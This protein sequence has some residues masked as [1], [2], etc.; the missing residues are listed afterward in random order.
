MAARGSRVLTGKQVIIEAA[1]TKAGIVGFGMLIMLVVVVA[2]V[3]IYAPFDVVSAWNSR[4]PWLDNPKVAAPEWMDWFTSRD[5]ARSLIVQ[6][7]DFTKSAGTN[8]EGTFK[9]IT[10]RRTFEWNSDEFP[11]E[12]VVR[13]FAQWIDGTPPPRV[14]AIWLRPDGESLELFNLFP[15]RRVPDINVIS[16]SQDAAV[17]ETVRSW[18]LGLGAEDQ[19]FIQPGSVIFARADGEHANNM[20]NTTSAAVLRGRYTLQLEAFAFDADDDVDS[21]FLAHGN[22]FGLVGTDQNRRDLF[23]GLLWGAPVALAFGTVAALLT[24]FSQVL[25]GALGAFYGGRWDEFIQRAADFFLILPVLPILILIGAFYTPSIWIILG[26]VVIF[27]LVGGTTKVIRSIVLQVKEDQ[28]IESARSYGASRWRILVRYILPRTLPYTF[29]LIALSVPAFIFLEAALSF[30]GLGDPL[31]PTW[32]KI[33]GDAQRSGA[34]FSGAWWWITFPALG[35]LFVTV[36]FA[37]LGYAFDKI[38]NP[39]L[40]EE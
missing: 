13:L 37:F 24:V 15:D 12:V 38:L 5:M 8:P 35:I 6:Q 10:L 11:S 23:I 29:A 14:K 25:L 30:L 7:D 2:I 19:A 1:K 31:L 16:I 3:P 22:I 20:L 32:G 4:Q 17:R 9:L 34:I 26:V 33:L 36:G 28:Y 40:R 21:M 39:R 27:S 18:A